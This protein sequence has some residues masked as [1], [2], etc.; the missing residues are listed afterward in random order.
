MQTYGSKLCK[1]MGK[2]TSR[3]ER[4]IGRLWPL[5]VKSYIMKRATK[6]GKLHGN[7]NCKA[8]RKEVAERKLFSPMAP[9]VSIAEAISRVD[10]RRFRSA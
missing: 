2:V 3:K 5:N 7:A 8:H 1:P 10:G 9:I 4:G 6:S